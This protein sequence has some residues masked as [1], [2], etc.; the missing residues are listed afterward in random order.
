M[1]DFVEEFLN[2]I[3]PAV[4]LWID[5][6]LNAPPARAWDV[7][8]RAGLFDLGDQPV[9][10]IA[11]VGDNIADIMQGDEQGVSGGLVIG[12]AGR[13]DE[14]QRQAARIDHGVPLRA[15]SPTRETDGVIRT[16][17]LPRSHAGERG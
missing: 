10:V 11:S 2:N 3:A 7:G 17:F 16:P 6:S 14:A 12:L 9:G 4:G 1:F 15:Q 8:G 13:Q 5:G